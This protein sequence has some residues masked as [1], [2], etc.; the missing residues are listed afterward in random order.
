MIQRG[1]RRFHHGVGGIPQPVLIGSVVGLGH[2][3]DIYDVGGAGIYAI[4]DTGVVPILEIQGLSA[5]ADLPTSDFGEFQHPGHGTSQLI[6]HIGII[7]V[8]N[9][10]RHKF[11]LDQLD[12]V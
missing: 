12:G 1:L 5:T 9:L 6:K 11:A 3:I 7:G 2:N 8:E 10:S 4:R